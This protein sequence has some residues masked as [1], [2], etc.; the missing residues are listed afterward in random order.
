MGEGIPDWRKVVPGE[1]ERIA[2]RSAKD[3]RHDKREGMTR[4]GF[5]RGVLGVATDAGIAAV[6]GESFLRLSDFQ[7]WSADRARRLHFPEWDTL[8]AAE[9]EKRITHELHAAREFIRGSE[10]TRILE[11]GSDE[12][13]FGL[14]NAM[15]AFLR[16]QLA[17][18]RYEVGKGVWPS[19]A[20]GVDSDDNKPY[21]LPL[22]YG[23]QE[24][25][26]LYHGNGVF[27][28]PDTVMT[29]CH[30]LLNDKNFAADSKSP[31]KE[32]PAVRSL[33][34]KY[35][36]GPLDVAFVRFDR[37][38]IFEDKEHTPPVFKIPHSLSDRDMTGEFFTVEGI[39]PDPHSATT[40]S[41][42]DG[43]KVYA[44]VAIPVTKRVAEFL[45][46]YDPFHI[47]SYMEASFLY[48]APPGESMPRPYAS[49]TGSRLLDV[50]EG[51]NT[52]DLDYLMHGMSG[53]P[54]FMNGQLVGIN[55]RLG[56]I[57]FKGSDLDIGFF[58]GPSGLQRA[59]KSM[60][61][62]AAEMVTTP[63]SYATTSYKWGNGYTSDSS[64]GEK[65]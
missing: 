29:N 60:T 34:H 49:A 48:I 45:R 39:D 56:Q 18:T 25:G 12:E 22:N 30:V 38:Y 50:L 5:L 53:S 40:S 57:R 16:D 63:S 61:I 2:G 65:R 23:K 19:V 35:A 9:R 3:I 54:V 28:A 7:A 32:L 4:R 41:A 46:R 58:F 10:G 17:G 24:I 8:S 44:S 15:P 62:R 1:R 36:S 21:A 47:E 55:H 51:K 27:V 43:T 13:I 33:W 14:I 11:S 31:I 26:S 59:S 42:A 6:A 20:V 37:P 64:S 52:R